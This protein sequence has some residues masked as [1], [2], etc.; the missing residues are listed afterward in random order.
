M[1][2]STIER[3]YNSYF[4]SNLDIN[5][6]NRKEYFNENNIKYYNRDELKDRRE[7]ILQI[8]YSKKSGKHY[9]L[10]IEGKVGNTTIS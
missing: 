7:F 10:R 5:I 2:D 6:I 4:K 9:D 8:H 3:I 1:S